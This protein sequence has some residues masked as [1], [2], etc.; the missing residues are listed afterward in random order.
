MVFRPTS[1]PCLRLFFVFV[2]ITFP[3]YKPDA[4]RVIERD[5]GRAPLAALA[6][7]DQAGISGCF[8]L[9]QESADSVHQEGTVCCLL[10]VPYPGFPYMGN[11]DVASLFLFVCLRAL[12]LV[13]NRTELRLD[14]VQL[15]QLRAD[16]FQ[17]FGFFRV[18]L[19]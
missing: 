15:F 16:R 1:F 11:R 6:A 19:A 14:P 3:F 7:A 10:E 12:R 5:N 2:R 18:A 17:R 4:V 9:P 13:K 8:L